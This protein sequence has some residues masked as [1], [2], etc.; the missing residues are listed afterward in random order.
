MTFG[1]GASPLLV[2]SRLGCDPS[3]GK[4][5]QDDFTGVALVR[6]IKEVD[7][8]GNSY[9][10]EELW[11]EHLSL[12]KRVNLLEKISQDQ[13]AGLPLNRV[14]IEGVAGFK[15]FVAE[16]KRRT[17][18]PVREA[19]AT[20]DKISHLES[21]SHYFEN[22]KVFLSN[23][24]PRRLRDMLVHQLTTNYPKKDDLRDALLLTLDDNAQ[25][26]RLTF[27]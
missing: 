13:P 6:K 26:Q 27:V 18:L 24:I 7:A 17:N 1:G 9:Y 21:K 23:K 5:M 25:R 15:D 20:K 22:G 19:N 10:I 3:I 11:N 14:I 12:N 4:N 8:S 16:V 2:E